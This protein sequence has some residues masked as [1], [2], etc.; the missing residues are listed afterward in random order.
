MLKTIVRTISIGVILISQVCIAKMYPIRQGNVDVISVKEH[1]IDF[2]LKLNLIDHA[3]KTIDISSF[4]IGADKYGVNIFKS[5]RN[6]LNRG[7][8]V[9][10][11]HEGNNF[12]LGGNKNYTMNL[13]SLIL[14]S[15]MSKIAEVIALGSL[16]KM[17]IGISLDDCIHQ[18]LI[19][20]DANTEN[21]KIYFG[22][23][24]LAENFSSMIDNGFL[25]RPLDWTQPYIGTD[26][27]ANFEDTWKTLSTYFSKEQPANKLVVEYTKREVAEK[28]PAYQIPSEYVET[29]NGIAAVV[30][31]KPAELILKEQSRPNSAQLAN[32][33]FIIKRLKQQPLNV[34]DD[35]SLKLLVD[36]ISRGQFV[37]SASYSADF[38][39]PILKSLVGVI[40]SGGKVN[41]YTNGL[42][43]M[44]WLDTVTTGELA[45]MSVVAFVYSIRRL[46]ELQF[47]GR[48]LANLNVFTVDRA[49]AQEE[50]HGRLKFLHRKLFL[51]DNNWVLS[52]SHNFTK[53]SSIKN[54]ELLVAFDDERM[55]AT[56]TQQ[57]LDEQRKFYN[58]INLSLYT[59]EYFSQSFFSI[60]EKLLGN[61]VKELF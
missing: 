39:L 30:G 5:L 9:R 47:Y 55:N 17:K 8:R 35:D 32:N 60:R 23:R 13:Q 56:L 28:Y 1:E 50:T 46:Q 44:K 14:D 58:Q 24:D 33:E 25:L 6:A 3:T 31:A 40:R 53:S 16:E 36:K 19:I 2:A 26:I 37:Q 57:N 15:K 7:V 34:E 10:V 61:K 20:V 54:D 12:R 49:K 59:K 48:N 18:K 21:E 29:Y 41:V 4:F 22:G 42:E 51:V 43:S 27:K 38:S 11:M 52:G 45:G